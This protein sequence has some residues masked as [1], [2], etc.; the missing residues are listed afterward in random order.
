[1]IERSRSSI[2][3][4]RDVPTA[5]F[6]Q[7]AWRSSGSIAS[8]SRRAAMIAASFSRSASIAPGEAVG[9]AGE[10]VEVRRR[11]EGLVPR[12]DLEDRPAAL[13]VGQADVDLAV[14]AAR[15][16]DGRV[17]DV[18]AVRRGDDDDVVGRAEAVELDEQLVERLLA[19]LVA[20]RAAAGLA[21]R[22]ELVEEDHAAAELAGLGEQ[23]A[24]PLRADADVLLDE[25]RA[26][27]VVERD[28]GLGGDG[29]G[30]HRLAGAGRAVE[31]DPARDPG[32]ER[33]EALGR[34]EELDRL[35]QLELRL[36]AAGDVGE[37]RPGRPAGAMPSATAA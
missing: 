8:P 35:G 25:L 20:V 22:V 15:P 13:H 37:G 30:E 29:P 2:D 4:R 6:S 31:H 33:A 3:R 16:E 26:G 14:E 5:T 1:M 27:R 23:V 17:E 34:A 28:A 36:V 10:L 19:L 18:E 7:P 21:D 11:R 32:A 24:D 9:L 12:V